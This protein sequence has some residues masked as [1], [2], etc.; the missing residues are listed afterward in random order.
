M[1]SRSRQ[2]TRPF[3]PLSGFS[4]ELQAISLLSTIRGVA[5]V[6]RLER[7]YPKTF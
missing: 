7:T 3:E 5:L 2:A 1:E 6:Q 4:S